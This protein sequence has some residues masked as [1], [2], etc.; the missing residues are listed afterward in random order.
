V[1]D[2]WGAVI[3][4]AEI[5]AENAGTGE[6]C[7]ATTNESGTYALTSLQPGTNVPPGYDFNLLHP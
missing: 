4:K 1:R 7:A 3:V 2:A 6:R 5:T